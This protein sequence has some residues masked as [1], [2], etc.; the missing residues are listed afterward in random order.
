MP[1][2][3]A[4]TGHDSRVPVATHRLRARVDRRGLV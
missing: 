1:G 3:L 2:V 4:F